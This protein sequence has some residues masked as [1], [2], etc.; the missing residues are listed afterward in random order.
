VGCDSSF[1]RKEAKERGK[2]KVSIF[3]TQ[4]RRKTGRNVGGT[5]YPP[6]RIDL[7]NLKTGGRDKRSPMG[8]RRERGKES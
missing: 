6:Q 3:S 4:R 5:W 2:E 8:L 7:T 1:V